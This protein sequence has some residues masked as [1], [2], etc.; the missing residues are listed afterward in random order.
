MPSS[1]FGT[2]NV[3][4]FLNMQQTAWWKQ[5]KRKC[6]QI[7]RN[8]SFSV[9]IMREHLSNQSRYTLESTNCPQSSSS[10]S[11]GFLNDS[12]M[13]VNSWT[14]AGF[15]L[16]LVSTTCIIPIW[17]GQL[18]WIESVLFCRWMTFFSLL[19]F[20]H[21]SIC[22]STPYLHVPSMWPPP[23]PALEQSCS[24]SV[25]CIK[26]P[27]SPWPGRWIT[28]GC[29]A[30]S[31]ATFAYL[32]YRSM[33]ALTAVHGS[34]HVCRVE[35]TKNCGQLSISSTWI[36]VSS[37]KMALEVRVVLPLWYS[38]FPLLWCTV[39]FTLKGNCGIFFVYCSLLAG[40]KR[41]LS[42]DMVSSGQTAVVVVVLF[43]NIWVV[44]QPLRCVQTLLQVWIHHFQG[45]SKT[46]RKYYEMAGTGS[47]TTAWMNRKGLCDG[48]LTLPL[49]SAAALPPQLEVQIA[50]FCF[51]VAP[52]AT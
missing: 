40:Y 31:T 11:G 6:T 43:C 38:L 30:S 35:G 48:L 20:L 46:Q 25:I 10:L 12:S 24:L 28:D 39:P 41:G 47:S 26:Q 27:I 18:G 22:I 7:S 15:I 4:L 49:E 44:M 34:N 23:P 29:S 13:C 33:F 14:D 2:G 5:I 32:T 1:V 50:F 8:W 51:S 37:Q 45:V 36:G 17:K 9:K 19:L 21:L 3:K 42:P 52:S 16:R